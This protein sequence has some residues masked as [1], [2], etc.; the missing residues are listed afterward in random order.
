MPSC[1]LPPSP[2]QNMAWSG[3]ALLFRLPV[4]ILFLSLAFRGPGCTRTQLIFITPVCGSCC[5]TGGETEA[6]NGSVTCPRQHSSPRGSEQR[7]P[8]HWPPSGW[9]QEEQPGPGATSR[10]CLAVPGALSHAPSRHTPSVPASPASPPSPTP[11][12]GRLEGESGRKGWEGGRQQEVR[13]V[14]RRFFLGGS[15]ETDAG[16][17]GVGAGRSQAGGSL[18]GAQPERWQGP[19]AWRG[20]WTPHVLCWPWPHGCS[21]GPLSRRT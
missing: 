16:A 3:A 4:S 18:L 13:G 5:F 20:P 12:L 9:P 1:S 2:L 15:E 21:E 19:G 10:E 14:G 7:V 17:A 11:A 6:Q 8:W